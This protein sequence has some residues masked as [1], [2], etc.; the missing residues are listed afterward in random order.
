MRAGKKMRTKKVNVQ[1]RCT[2]S[3]VS[4]HGMTLYS[5][6]VLTPIRQPPPP[7]LV[8]TQRSIQ[9]PFSSHAHNRRQRTHHQPRRH[10][11]TKAERW[12]SANAVCWSLCMC[13]ALQHAVVLSQYL[14]TKQS[15]RKIHSSQF[16]LNV[17]QYIDVHIHSDHTMNYICMYSVMH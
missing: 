14:L 7:P 5:T 12:W 6:A 11:E 4:L 1:D 13:T 3:H 16:H 2:C 10:V 9:Q 17:V 8:P 15:S